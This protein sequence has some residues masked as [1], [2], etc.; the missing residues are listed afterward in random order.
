MSL[1]GGCA[2]GTR[3]VD[4]FLKGWRRSAPRSRSTAAMCWPRRRAAA[5]RRP[6]VFPNVSVGATHTLMMAATLAQGRDGDRERRARA[7]D[8]DLA[9]CLITMG[10]KIEGAGTHDH[11]HRRRRPAARRGASRSSPTASRPAPMRW[12]SRWP[13]ATSCCKGAAAELLQTALDAIAAGRRGGRDQA[14]DGIRVS[15]NGAAS[16]RSTSRPSR[17][18]AS[19]PTCRRSSWR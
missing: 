15:R 10:A 17:F 2:I 1:P 13:A 16:R 11:P 5:Q 4:F 8:R 9:D 7:G 3:P 18:P 6:I 14:N 19:R 12:P